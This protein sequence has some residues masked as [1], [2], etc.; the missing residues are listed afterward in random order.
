MSQRSTVSLIRTECQD[1]R[2]HLE[3]LP[4]REDALLFV[5]PGGKPLRYDQWREA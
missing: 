5:T 3:T 4:S 1:A 2:S